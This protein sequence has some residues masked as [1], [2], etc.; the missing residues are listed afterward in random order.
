[1]RIGRRLVVAPAFVLIGFGI[2]V[3]RAAA[4]TTALRVEIPGAPMHVH[5]SDGREYIEYDLVISNGFL[6]EVT[7]ESVTVRGGGRRLLRLAGDALA[8]STHDTL[9]GEPSATIPASSTVATVIDVVLLRS[10]GRRVPRRLT[11]RID[12]AL[13][14]MPH[15]GR[16]SE[17]PPSGAPPA[18]N[19]AGRS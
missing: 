10:A 6:A 9:G 7:L 15:C 14:R 19:G 17:A 3:P 13:P 18:S 12:Y 8:N 11:T 2:A 1:M 16:S 4:D 5:G